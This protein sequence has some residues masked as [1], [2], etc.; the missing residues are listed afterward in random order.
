MLGGLIHDD[1][2][3]SN[4]RVPL[5]GDIPLF[6]NLFKARGN[7]KSK[8]I[9]WFFRPTVLRTQDD[10]EDLSASKT[11]DSEVEIES[12]NHQKSMIYS[13]AL[14]LEQTELRK[15]LL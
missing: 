10:A 8:P 9:F 5:V 1:I 15:E 14:D 6:G 13:R 11:I 3:I 2:N 4:N 7:N 12:T